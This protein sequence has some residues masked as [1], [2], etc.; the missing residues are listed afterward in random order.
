MSA[1]QRVVTRK[2]ESTS[3]S[4]ACTPRGRR[5]QRDVNGTNS[6]A[7]QASSPRK[8]IQVLVV[9]AY[10][11]ALYLRKHHLVVAKFTTTIYTQGTVPILGHLEVSRLLLH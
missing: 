7:V 11:L 5:L 6:S 10:L 4:I 8:A 3:H 2:Q 9:G 1:G